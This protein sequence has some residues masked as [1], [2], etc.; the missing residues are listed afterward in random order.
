MYE[1]KSVRFFLEFSLF[2]PFLKVQHD[3]CT[4]LLN[5]SRIK[6]YN[7]NSLHS[8]AMGGTNKR[9]ATLL[10]LLVVVTLIMA[11][12]WLFS[13]SADTTSQQIEHAE[14][15]HGHRDEVDDNPPVVH[16]TL[17]N[18]VAATGVLSDDLT[19]PLPERAPELGGVAVGDDNDD[20]GGDENN[21]NEPDEHEDRVDNENDKE[22][23]ADIQDALDAVVDTH[24]HVE[25]RRERVEEAVGA[26][27]DSVHSTVVNTRPIEA[28][29]RARDQA[30]QEKA[31][32]DA[33]QKVKQ[34]HMAAEAV[35]VVTS[36][37]TEAVA[38]GEVQEAATSSDPKHSFE[39]VVSRYTT[40]EKAAE[41][42]AKYPGEGARSAILHL[43]R[44]HSLE[45]QSEIPPIVTDVDMLP[46][47]WPSKEEG[48]FVHR[49]VPLDARPT[50][51]SWM[52]NV[53]MPLWDMFERFRTVTEEEAKKAAVYYSEDPKR[54]KSP[55]RY[56][57]SLQ[58]LPFVSGGRQYVELYGMSCVGELECSLVLNHFTKG[59][60]KVAVGH[61]LIIVGARQDPTL[62]PDLRRLASMFPGRFSVFRKPFGLSCSQ[63]F[64]TISRIGFTRMQPR[65][66][67]VQ[68]ANADY[69][70]TGNGFN[71]YLSNIGLNIVGRAVLYPYGVHEWT[72]SNFGLPYT[73]YEAV[74][75]F[76][77]AI[78]PAAVEDLDFR[79]RAS[80]IGIGGQWKYDDSFTYIHYGGGST[81]QKPAVGQGEAQQPRS[82]W[83]SWDYV[84]RKHN[85]FSYLNP[86]SDGERLN[87]FPFNMSW[88]PINASFP[89]AVHQQCIYTKA[90]RDR[91]PL[92]QPSNGCLGCGACYWNATRALAPYM[93]LAPP[94]TTL[95]RWLTSQNLHFMQRTPTERP[96]A[97]AKWRQLKLDE[98]LARGNGSKVEYYKEPE[99]EEA[100]A[101]RK[102]ALTARRL[103]WSQ[104]IPVNEVARREVEAEL[105]ELAARKAANKTQG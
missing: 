27:R 73:M 42:A 43:I 50:E 69:Y 81:S 85:Y 9:S 55:M 82:G 15:V 95:P 102:A 56:T 28:E 94:G 47:F 90:G 51:D 10:P 65:P 61:V 46:W 97:R 8:G 40:P 104:L 1:Y 80:W 74:G 63:S 59:L 66:F 58:R 57:E 2:F 92:L 78:A 18:D 20:G 14:V 72:W 24:E 41:L 45:D 96:E 12:Q 11:S 7:N 64:N 77:E 91:Y 31:M 101:A 34:Y 23:P 105:K 93:H 99:R 37:E 3:I 16:H 25:K 19:Q 52:S 36:Q 79:E 86:E 22:I 84:V 83:A 29:V 60:S 98:G 88:L 21:K 13:N 49:V 26:A 35:A 75:P 70:P 5:I 67:M 76:D 54:V 89:D 62:L 30:R 53:T 87:A 38:K 6:Y 39:A 17:S 44:Y 68:I 48:A 100:I 4:Q 71:L 32:R 33:D 103:Y